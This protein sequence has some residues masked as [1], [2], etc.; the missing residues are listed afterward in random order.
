MFRFVFGPSAGSALVRA[1]AGVTVNGN[2]TVA[3]EAV[4][5]EPTM[6]N[7]NAEVAA[8]AVVGRDFLVNGRLNASAARFEGP[9]FVSGMCD[10]VDVTAAATSEFH[11]GLSA[12]GSRFAALSLTGSDFNINRCIVDVITVRPLEGWRTRSR[13]Y[14]TDTVVH[15][16]IRAQLEEGG[17]LDATVILRGTSEVRGRLDGVRLIDERVAHGPAL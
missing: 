4:L 14:L 11:G 17:P 6:V 15:G 12:R 7:G 8:G 5:R 1:F 16:D 3:R 2:Y 9:L 10:F 13:I